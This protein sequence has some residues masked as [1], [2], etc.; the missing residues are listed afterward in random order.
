ML[1]A[2]LEEDV[3][4]APPIHVDALPRSALEGARAHEGTLGASACGPLAAWLDPLVVAEDG[5]VLPWTYGI[6][7][8]FAI[9]DARSS[10]LSR[11][12]AEYREAGLSKALAYAAR[13]RDDVLDRKPWPYVNWFGEL[14]VGGSIPA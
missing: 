13:V 5:V 4:D 3:E 14:A 10:R 8:K 11:M 7:R 1:A 9:G 2:I 6:D 12:S